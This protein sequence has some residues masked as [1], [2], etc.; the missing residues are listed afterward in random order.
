M[1]AAIQTGIR[2]IEL[3]E[4]P[5]PAPD[6]STGLVRVRSAGICGSDL[7]PY[8][9]R[10]EPQTLP[11]GHEVAGEVIHLPAGYDGPARVGDLVAVDT[12]LG[13]ACGDCAF[14]RA[15]Q[16]FHCPARH[17]ANPPGGGFAEIMKRRPAGFFPLAPGMSAQQGALV[18]PLAVGV[19][20]VRWSRMAEA[21]TV[22]IIGAGTIGLTTLMAARALGAGSVHITARHA[23][24]AS[25]ATDLGATSVLP[26]SPAAATEA[27]QAL[28][29]GLGAD[30]V[31]ETVGGHADT[32]NL[33]WE[34]VKPQGTVGV[35]G[36]FPDPVPVNLL[37]PLQKEVWVTFPI[38][39]G[40]IDGRHDFQVAIDL[41]ASGKAPVER[42]VTREFPLEQA[43]LAFQTAADKSTGSVK[44][45]LTNGYLSRQ[46]NPRP[47][48]LPRP[49]S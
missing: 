23:H 7:H 42:M 16:P 21:A 19:H 4:I 11:A 1:R 29:D 15:G 47:N 8:H 32:L 27:V 35:L 44:I 5:E 49:G 2:T 46:K 48:P 17:V 3:R 31:I 24:Q 38:C 41:I 9:G 18:E 20:G 12:I 14:C 30:L 26:E 6:A 40:Y 22:V 36:V 28:T 45:H 43:P 37:R 39:Y 34:L 13:M 33:A 25:M 10:A